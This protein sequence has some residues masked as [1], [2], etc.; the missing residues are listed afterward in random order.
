M[1]E[2][3]VRQPRWDKVEKLYDAV[4]ESLVK[5]I[6]EEDLNFIEISI[7]MMMINSKL[8]QQKMSAYLLLENQLKSEE[9]VKS[10]NM[11]K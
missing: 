1:A 2:E 7:A 6:E 3:E 5:I 10:S 9:N 8:D 11:Y 4:D